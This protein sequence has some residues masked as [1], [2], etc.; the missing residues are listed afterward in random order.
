MGIPNTYY[1]LLKDYKDLDLEGKLLLLNLYLRLNGINP[2]QER[3]HTKKEAK[4]N[5]RINVDKSG[6][7]AALISIIRRILWGKKMLKN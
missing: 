6:F 5:K 1:Y 4:I 3:F 2:K 7:I